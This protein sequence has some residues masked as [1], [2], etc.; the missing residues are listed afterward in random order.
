MRE[1]ACDNGG[2][3]RQ[4]G[5][6]QETTKFKAG[7]LPLNMY[8]SLCKQAKTP[9]VNFLGVHLVMWKN[10]AKFGTEERRMSI[11]YGSSQ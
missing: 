6:R 10:G 8:R 1:W 9:K 2:A 4:R 5:F 11:A 3:F 7:S